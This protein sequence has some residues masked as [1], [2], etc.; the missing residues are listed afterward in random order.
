M[1]SAIDLREKKLRPERGVLVGAGSADVQHDPSLHVLDELAEL[2]KTAGVE[3]VARLYQRRSKPDSTF[4]VGKGKVDEIAAARRD[5]DADVV[6]FDVELSPRQVRNLEARVGCKVIDR[7]EV[8]LDIFAT[9]AKTLEARLQV[10]LAQLRYT[11]PRLKRMWTHLSRIAGQGGIGSRG[12]G[13]KQIETDRRLIDQR[14]HALEQE[15]KEIQVRKVRQVSSRRDDFTVSLVGYTN[16]GKS[17]MM[18]RLTG[19]DV[20]Q[21]DQL[22]ATL[23]TKTSHFELPSGNQ[24]LLSDTVGFV[25]NLPHHL[26]ASFHATM[27]E[28]RQAKLLLHVVDA[29]SPDFERQIATVEHVLFEEIKIGEHPQI[30]VLNKIDLVEDRGRLRRAVADRG[31]SYEVS[32]RTGEG[33]DRLLA[34]VTRFDDAGRCVLELRLA[35][36]DGKTLAELNRV[37]EVLES[38]YEGDHLDLRVRLPAEAVG[39]FERWAR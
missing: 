5:F 32:A 4:Y 19:A 2:A 1:S 33:I 22:F 38:A 24:V 31:E 29:S 35:A 34:A 25:E 11:R 13:E 16:A 21:A 14:I 37:G 6:L 9:H 12:P 3:S 7:S 23:D 30:L 17:T 8:I 20:Y 18:H 26:V 27:E 15:L 10:E 36:G 39:Y 28:V